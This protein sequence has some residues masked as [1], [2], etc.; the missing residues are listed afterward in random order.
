MNPEILKLLHQLAL[1]GTVI[2]TDKSKKYLIT[3]SDTKEFESQADIILSAFRKM[4]IET[5]NK[6]LDGTKTYQGSAKSLFVEK[7][8]LASKEFRKDGDT[9]LNLYDGFCNSKNCNFRRQGFPFVGN[10][11]NN[12]FDLIFDIVQ[13]EIFDIY[14]CKSFECNIS[15]IEK[16]IEIKIANN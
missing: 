14:Q 4:D 1:L 9:S 12:Y 16:I 13:G 8:A 11:S 15:G 6:N 2:Y 7:L 10:N 5:I 3:E